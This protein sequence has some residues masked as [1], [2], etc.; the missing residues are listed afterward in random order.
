[1]LWIIPFTLFAQRTV[2]GRITD[3]EDG[4][5][6]P[7]ASVFIANT[8]VGTITDSVGHYRLT[9]PGEGSY[10]LTVSH[11]GYQP[12]FKDI[13]PG[14][15]SI[16]LDVALQSHLLDEVK[17]GVKVHFRQR[18]INLF[19]RT[20]LGKSPSRRTVQP[21]NPEA[22][23][24]YYNRET[25]I[26]KVTCRVPLQI[27]NNETGYQIQLVIDHFTHDYN[28]NIS[29]WE[30]GCIFNELE[31]TN[32]S[33]KNAWEANR[34]KAYQVS[35]R[36]FIKSLY[37]NTL[38]ENGFLLVYPKKNDGSKGLRDVYENPDS[39]LTTDIAGVSKTL[40]IPTNLQDYLMLICF[41]EPVN[42]RMLDR[43]ERQQ[44][45]S[46]FSMGVSLRVNQP[47]F[48]WAKI[49]LYRNML[50]T[51][52]ESVRIFPDGTYV[53]PLMVTSCFSSNSILGL[54]LILPLDYNPD[55]DSGAMLSVAK[56]DSVIDEI[57]LDNR[58]KRQME[59]YPQEK[60][61][62]HTDRDVYVPGEK[63]WFKAYVVDAQTHLSPTYSQYVYVEL[64]SPADTLVK[65][66]M[67]KQT[68]GMF[69]GHLPIT[70][71]IPEG[72]YTLR[73]YTR[74]MENLGDDYFFKKNIRIGS[75]KRESTNAR[76]REG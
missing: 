1:M 35:L 7:G 12:E 3:A 16:I 53:N 31:T 19:W 11:V 45:L 51:P 61:H 34:K 58:F 66:V 67:V 43:L 10:R 44:Q 64:I 25:R 22:V 30:Y 5:P 15:S 36:N 76:T 42:H 46:T 40:L 20:V 6:V 28:T 59:I 63:I 57:L 39:F 49:G 52:S 74:Y 2:S 55:I 68:D 17:V 37:N 29:S 26:L 4:Q 71:A 50:E 8:S 70:E 62:I 9:I 69:Y 72:N 75:I 18:D 14:H 60:L 33:Q 48:N 41:G 27:I 21:M 24:Y 73:A 47:S 32:N 65:R 38:M 23:Y 56:T 54:N 13:E